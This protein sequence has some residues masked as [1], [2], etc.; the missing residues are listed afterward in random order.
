MINALKHFFDMGGYS[1]YVWTAYGSVGLYLFAQWYIPWRRW[2]KH[3]QHHQ[4]K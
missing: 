3:L 2:K 1:F 4:I